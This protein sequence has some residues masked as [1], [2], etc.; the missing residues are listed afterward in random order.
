MKN[1]IATVEPAMHLSSESLNT[2]NRVAGYVFNNG[3]V[4]V[5]FYAVQTGVELPITGVTFQL[6][7]K[8]IEAEGYLPIGEVQRLLA[9]DIQHLDPEY[10]SYLLAKKAAKYGISDI[11][12]VVEH[13][14][15]PVLLIEAWFCLGEFTMK[16]AL[17]V[18]ELF[19]EEVFLHKKKQML[20]EQIKLSVSWAPFETA[21]NT[22]EIA[23]LTAH[24]LV[25]VYPK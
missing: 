3:A 7:Q 22:E 13:A 2:V 15:D 11:R 19:V 21:L 1:Q 8:G 23:T 4:E 14:E 5:E 17:K 9:L 10:V 12:Y 18:D 20:S 24:D 16:G 6:N 25:L